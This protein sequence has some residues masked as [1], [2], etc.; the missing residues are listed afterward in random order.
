MKKRLKRQLKR[1]IKLK[2]VFFFFEEINKI[3]VLLAG[4]MKKKRGLNKIRKGRGDITTDNVI[5]DIQRIIRDYC[6]QLCTKNLNNLK[7]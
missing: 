1:S 7:K 5:T 3:D 2:L 4:F 6:E